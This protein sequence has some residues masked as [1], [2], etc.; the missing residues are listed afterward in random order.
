MNNIVFHEMHQ[1]ARLSIKEV[2]E[3]LKDFGL[4]SAQWSILYS[5]KQFGEMTQTNIWKYLHV[6]APT[7]TR[8]LMKLEQRKLIIR[9]EGNDKRERIV[10]LT[11]QAHIMI[12][13]IEA[14]IAEVEGRLLQSLSASEVH[15]L[16]R[17]LKKIGKDFNCDGK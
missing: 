16:T 9:K 11:E 6:E 2:N 14:K 10:Q 5:L 12:P 7:V 17:L 4:Y 1:K 15:E 3:T 8:T 13:K